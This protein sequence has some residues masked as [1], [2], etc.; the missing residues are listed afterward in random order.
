MYNGCVTHLRSSGV[1][2]RDDID[3]DVH[4][5]NTY[6]VLRQTLPQECCS[7]GDI[8]TC[9]TSTSRSIYC[10]LRI[11]CTETTGEYAALR[12]YPSYYS[13]SASHVWALRV[14][15][16]HFRCAH[17]GLRAFPVE[18][19]EVPDDEERFLKKP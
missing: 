19:N 13:A 5:D 10:E 4:V 11:F 12:L 3:N 7:S 8:Y 6:C 1:L 9:W 14:R 17:V 18:H 16:K 15:A 2:C